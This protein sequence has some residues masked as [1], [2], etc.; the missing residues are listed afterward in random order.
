MS[1]RL[2]ILL[3]L[4]ACAF[5]A[6]AAL[7]W[8]LGLALRPVARAVGA[9]FERYETDGYAR[10]RLQGVTYHRDGLT[11]KADRIE[12]DSP[13]VWLGRRLRGSDPV[14]VVD[15]WQVTGSARN[16]SGPA[17][18]TGLA[19]LQSLLGRV[20]PRVIFWVPKAVLNDG[21]VRGYGPEV[22]L[23]HADWDR[24]GLR[25]NG[26]VFAG[27][28]LEATLTFSGR[29]LRIQAS[30]T[31]QAAKLDLQV[32][33][34]A[35]NGSLLWL[36]QEARFEAAFPASGWLPRTASVTAENWA[37]PAGTVRLAPVY[38]TV[39]GTAN[40]TW[41]DGQW[42]L[43]VRAQATPDEAKEAPPFTFRANAHGDLRGLTV[44]T[45]HVDAPFARAR[46]SAPVTIALAGPLPEQNAR[47]EVEAD[48]AKL[49]WV[50]ARGRRCWMKRISSRS[51]R[52]PGRSSKASPL[53][54]A[55]PVARPMCRCCRPSTIRCG[56]I[57]QRWSASAWATP[58]CGCAPISMS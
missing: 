26:L 51:R 13:L 25:A 8:W 35:L 50:A 36:G 24:S 54:P 57:R 47:L 20:L 42:R 27:H 9:G 16:S 38:A 14:I 11:V 2:K 22:L 30:E 3:V 32:R 55:S 41:N 10:F 23:A 18:V 44:E 40:A 58:C 19:D 17:T 53:L 33:E 5:V 28:T 7:P 1:S 52:C 37:L 21:A 46:L 4:F 43:D 48:V 6:L 39:E 49:P 34:A 29:D 56:A 15:G 45:L 31:A 12:A